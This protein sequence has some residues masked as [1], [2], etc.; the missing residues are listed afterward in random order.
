[1]A[2]E[3]QPQGPYKGEVGREEERLEADNHREAGGGDLAADSIEVARRKVARAFPHA[4][5]GM[6]D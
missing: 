4:E 1:M 2:G 5:E 3:L 6:Q